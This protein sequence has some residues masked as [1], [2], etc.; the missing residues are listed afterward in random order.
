RLARL[1]QA[2][3]TPDVA[4]MPGSRPRWTELVAPAGVLVVAPAG[5]AETEAIP[6]AMAA[7]APVIGAAPRSIGQPG[8]H[9]R[10]GRSCRANA[11]RALAAALLRL[12]EDAGLRRQIAEIARGQAYEV[13]SVRSFIDNHR[14]VYRNALSARAVGEGVSDMAMVA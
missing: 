12:H 14:A 8:A 5:G 11:P 9:H 13:F 10:K 3:H 1:A 6:R 4:V 2:S 7:G